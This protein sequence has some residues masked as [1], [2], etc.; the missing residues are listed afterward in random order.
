MLIF[1]FDFLTDLD[2]SVLSTIGKEI[3][4]LVPLNLILVAPHS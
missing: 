3:N 4:A 2:S 1:F